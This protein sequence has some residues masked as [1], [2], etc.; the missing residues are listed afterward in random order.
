MTSPLQSEVRQVADEVWDYR[1]RTDPVVQVRRGIPVQGLRGFGLAVVEE[2][3]RFAAKVLERLDAIGDPAD[4][5]DALTAGFLRHQ[6][7]LAV[8]APDHFWHGF[9]ISPYQIGSWLTF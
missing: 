8:E 2:D 4:H 7:G 1:L 6:L 5:D 3:A 9:T